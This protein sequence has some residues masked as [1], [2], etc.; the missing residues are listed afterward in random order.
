MIPRTP[1]PEANTKKEKD[2]LFGVFESVAKPTVDSKTICLPENGLVIT[3]L[4]TWKVP[5]EV[6]GNQRK[7]SELIKKQSSDKF[8]WYL[9]LDTCS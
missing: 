7:S 5:K 6:T 2:S 4:P 1:L 8:F 3:G 9:E